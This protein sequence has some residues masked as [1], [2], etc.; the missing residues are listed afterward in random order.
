VNAVNVHERVLPASADEV[1]ALI[2]RPERMWPERWP[3]LRLDS[4]IRVGDESRRGFICEEVVE[5]RAGERLAFRMTSPA[6]LHGKHRFEVEPVGERQTVLRHVVDVAPDGAARL[7]W[8]LVVRPLHDALLED[9]LDR[10]E[11][12]VG[13]SPAPRAW[14]RRV[15]LLRWYIGRRQRR[16]R[17]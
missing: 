17:G 2:D 5:Y 4:P 3:A 10:A 7:L 12:A 1:G 16:N 15:R 14:S 11:T 8:P 13:G 6:Q 9:L